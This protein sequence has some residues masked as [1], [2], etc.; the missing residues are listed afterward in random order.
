MTAAR[1]VLAY[2][3]FVEGLVPPGIGT[4]LVTARGTGLEAAQRVRARRALESPQMQDAL[5]SLADFVREET[6]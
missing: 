4:D 1:D 3:D 2:I 5:A 6:S